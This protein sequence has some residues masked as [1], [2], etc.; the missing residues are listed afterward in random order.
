MV[1]IMG[2]KENYISLKK[3]QLRERTLLNRQHQELAHK[4]QRL[5]TELKDK[6]NEMLRD[7]GAREDFGITNQK[8]WQQKI[9]EITR[10]EEE[11]NEKAVLQDEAEVLVLEANIEWRAIDITD[12][13]WNL[14][15][16]IEQIKEEH[17][18]K[19][20]PYMEKKG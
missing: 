15:I 13:Y 19:L 11:E 16:G 10:K 3:E 12:A 6:R 17:D 1:D 5:A 8:D 9:N 20:L 2:L 7:K 18:E 4:K 14:Q